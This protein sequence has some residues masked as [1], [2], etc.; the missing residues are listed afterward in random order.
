[1]RFAIDTAERAVVQQP[2]LNRAA[3]PSLSPALSSRDVILITI[4]ERFKQ[5]AF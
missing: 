1:M 5:V 3:F 4:S 2:R